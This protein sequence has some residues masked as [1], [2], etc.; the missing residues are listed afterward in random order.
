M[1][2]GLGQGTVIPREKW[3]WLLEKPKVSLFVRETTKAAWGI[4]NLYNRS[5]T[6]FPCSLYLHRE[7]EGDSA[8]LKK[9][10]LPSKEAGDSSW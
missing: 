7:N 8:M 4:K 3:E 5:V 1:Q 6:G 10:A 9:K 2:V